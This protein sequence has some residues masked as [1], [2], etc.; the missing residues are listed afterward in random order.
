MSAE[1]HCIFDHARR[2]LGFTAEGWRLFLLDWGGV[3]SVDE[4]HADTP[5]GHRASRRVLDRLIVAGLAHP[6]AGHVSADY[7]A[8]VLRL[9]AERGLSDAD[10][11]PIAAAIGHEASFP[12][13]A[14]TGQTF[15]GFVAYFRALACGTPELAR[16]WMTPDRLAFLDEM[17]R[18]WRVER[19]A[20]ARMLRDYGGGVYRPEHLD[21]MGFDRVQVALEAKAG[22][23]A[24]RALGRESFTT[25]ADT[26]VRRLWPEWHRPI[27]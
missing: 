6:R 2:A 25:A 11:A 15:Q 10:M 7:L 19:R 16:S 5:E 4:L 17:S 27:A 20:F 13:F 8:M 14:M 23:G 18:A 1:T 22:A 26:P 21:E 24:A 12:V 3:E 9:K